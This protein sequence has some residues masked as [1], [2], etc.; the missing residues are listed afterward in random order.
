MKCHEIRDNVQ[1][2]IDNEVPYTIRQ[3]IDEHM[4]ECV[5]CHAFLESY[6]KLNAILTLRSVPDPG[7]AYWKVTWEKIRKRMPARSYALAK[8]PVAAPA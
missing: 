1:D 4:V 6:R 5:E 2:Y 3:V 8:P 7:E